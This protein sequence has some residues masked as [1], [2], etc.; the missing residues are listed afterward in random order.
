V[1]IAVKGSKIVGVVEISLDDYSIMQCRG[2]ANGICDYSERI[3][4]II[5]DNTSLIEERKR[6]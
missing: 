4:G 6:A 5:N 3:A 1:L 2:F